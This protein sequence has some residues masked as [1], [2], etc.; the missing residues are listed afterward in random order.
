M[1]KLTALDQFKNQEARPGVRWYQE[2]YRVYKI[3]C[4]PTNRSYIGSTSMTPMDR[5]HHHHRAAKKE[6]LKST[7]REFY[8]DLLKYGL[9]EF[10]A[11]ELKGDL[12]EEEARKLEDM[13]IREHATHVKHAGAKDGVQYGGYNQQF[14]DRKKQSKKSKPH[15]ASRVVFMKGPEEPNGIYFESVGQAHRYCQ[16]QGWVSENSKGK[17]A[18]SRLKAA[19]KEENNKVEHQAFGH[20]WYYMTA[21]VSNRIA[22]VACDAVTGD[23]LMEFPDGVRALA[24]WIHEQ[25]MPFVRNGV[26]I[27]SIASIIKRKSAIDSGAI[28][29]NVK[30]ESLYEE[31]A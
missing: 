14:V 12:T 17:D 23:V 20:E 29:F 5:L 2:L 10:D 3:T 24:R 30:I 8:L 13:L 1:K 26:E 4:R 16:R 25:G 9:E 18:D 19:L 27:S 22:V 7:K 28:V 21:V 6:T 15:N 31:P 11:V